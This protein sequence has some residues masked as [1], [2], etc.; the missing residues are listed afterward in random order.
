V[1]RFPFNG[2]VINGSPY[3]ITSNSL[4]LTYRA[5]GT[6]IRLKPGPVD[7]KMLISKAKLSRLR[8]LIQSSNNK[9]LT[10]I[11]R[12]A[13][14]A[15]V[16]FTNGASEYLLSGAIKDTSRIKRVSTRTR[17]SLR[18]ALSREAAAI[19]SNPVLKPNQ[20][21]PV[22]QPPKPDP[23]PEPSPTPSP[24]G[25]GGGGGIARTFLLNVTGSEIT[26]GGTATGQISLTGPVGL[27]STFTREG[28]TQTT[29][30]SPLNTYTITLSATNNN[31]DASA[32]TSG[33]NVTGSSVAD[34]I[35]GALLAD[36]IASG[37]GNDTVTGNDGNDTITGGDGAD[38]LGG[39]NNNDV[40]LYANEAQLENGTSLVDS[41]INGGDGT[42]RISVANGLN[43][44]NT[45]SFA[46]ATSIEELYV[47][48]ASPSSI[49]LDI[50]AQIAGINAVN[51]STAT[52]NSTVDVSE[53][54]TTAVNITGGTAND[55][56]TGGGAADTLTGGLGNDILSGGLGSDLFA[57]TATDQGTDSIT[58]FDIA[59]DDFGVKQGSGFFNMGIAPGQFVAGNFTT[60]ATTADV[61]FTGASKSNKAVR[62]TSAQTTAEL[63]AAVTDGAG[64]ALVLAFNSDTGR[65]ELYYDFNWGDAGGRSLLA[66]LT[67]LTTLASINTVNENNFIALV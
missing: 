24:S 45:V 49:A 6:A 50:T 42:D 13:N 35:Q 12:D 59:N 56:L 54:T 30:L 52:A 39:G 1:P 41:A 48:G 16:N 22:I 43:I 9:K 17:K 7:G 25:G 57:Y 60:V 66:N 14:G 65:A 27:T 33:I 47:T 55:N 36:V 63:T 46:N 21:I 4:Q 26:F 19:L 34:I 44:A 62:L 64:N 2:F 15:E 18:V 61:T 67:S 32:Y 51:I 8:G 58:D 37:D 3:S 5:A 28:L 31:L 11:I 10:T 53:F 20:L 40:F 38:S 29:S 23:S